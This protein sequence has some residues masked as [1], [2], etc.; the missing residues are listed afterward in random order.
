MELLYGTDILIWDPY[1][2]NMK[3]KKSISPLS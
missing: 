1:R 3:K 2:G